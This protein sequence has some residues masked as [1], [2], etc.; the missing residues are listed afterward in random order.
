M[1]RL[2]IS[3]MQ[4]FEKPLQEELEQKAQVRTFNEGDV[5]IEIDQYIKSIPIVVKGTVKVIREDVEGNE[6]FLYYVNA[7]STCAMSLTCCMRD[8]KSQ[9]RAIAEEPVELMAIPVKEMDRWMMEYRSWKDFVMRS[10][11][12][13]F[14]ELLNTIDLIAFHH[15]DNRLI[16]YLEKKAEVH[17]SKSINVKHQEIAIEL[18]SSREAVSRLLKKLEQ[19]G[20]VKLHRNRIELLY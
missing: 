1:E 17:Q 18:S 15:M 9:I 7:G 3:M 2:P 11:S 6:L 4:L 14:E 16:A 13:R 5:I 8:Q 19:M 10:Y 20:K 12:S